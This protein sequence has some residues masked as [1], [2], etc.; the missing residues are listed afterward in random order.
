MHPKAWELQARTDRFAAA[1]IE[2][3]ER[4]PADASAQRIARKLTASAKA[5]ATG[6]KDVCASRTPERFIDGM[7]AVASQAKQAKRNLQLLLQLNHV[8]IESCRELLFEARGLENIF[9]AS[10]NTAKKRRRARTAA[11]RPV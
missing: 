8:T 7:S 11:A 5:M 2:L 4:L 10:R 3:C 9:V 1:A 6:Y